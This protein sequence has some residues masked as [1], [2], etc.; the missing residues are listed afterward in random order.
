MFRDAEVRPGVVL[1]QDDL[2][3]AIQ[4]V[5]LNR[6]TGPAQCLIHVVLE[7]ADHSDPRWAVADVVTADSS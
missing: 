1:H 4:F 7:R 5:T 2:D 3:G 6:A